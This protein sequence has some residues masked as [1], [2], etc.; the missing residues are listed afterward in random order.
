MNKTSAQNW[1]KLASGALEE[2]IKEALSQNALGALSGAGLGA[3]GLGLMGAGIGGGAGLLSGLLG[4]KEEGQSRW[5]QMMRRFGKGVMYGGGAGALGGAGLGAHAGHR[6]SQALQS[7]EFRNAMEE[8][9]S[10]MKNKPSG[11]NIS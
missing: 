5:D 1:Y 2:G 11:I 10:Q 4:K 6:T 3:G 8:A 7:P 9:L